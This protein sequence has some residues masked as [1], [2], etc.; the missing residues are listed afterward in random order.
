[1]KPKSITLKNYKRYGDE[2]TTLDLSGETVRLLVGK[3]GSGKTSFVDAIVWSLF[4]K[5]TANSDDVVNRQ[6]GKNCKVEFIFIIDQDEYS[7]IR[8]RK[9]DDYGNKVLVFKNK[10]NISP[11]RIDEANTLISSII[12]T[13][14]V[15]LISAV[16][17]SSEIYSSFLRGKGADRLKI[18]EN[19]LSLKIVNKWNEEIKK[20]RK[21]VIDNITELTEK[22]NKILVGV[23]TIDENI[24]NY[25]QRVKNTL[26]DLKKEKDDLLNFISENEGKLEEYRHIDIEKNLELNSLSD[27]IIKQ[28]KILEDKINIEKEKLKDINS[29]T[30]ELDLLK[31]KLENINNINVEDLIKEIKE[32]EIIKKKF[33]NLN[34]EKNKLEWQLID[35]EKELINIDNLSKQIILLFTKKKDVEQDL[36]CPTCHQDIKDEEAKNFTF[37]SIDNEIKKKQKESEEIDKRIFEAEANNKVIINDLNIILVKIKELNFKEKTFQYTTEEL[38]NFNKNKNEYY[39][40]ISYL[41]NNIVN[42]EKWNKEINERINGLKKELKEVPE[43]ETSAYESEFLLNLK[44][45]IN[46]LDAQ[47]ENAKQQISVIDEK[48]KSTYDKNYI[49]ELNTKVKNLKEHLKTTIEKIQKKEFEDKHYV[50]SLNF[51]SNDEKGFKRYVIKDMIDV[52]NE[53]L[54][55][56]VPMFFVDDTETVEITFD[57]NLV[58]TIKVDE[59]E[60]N[61]DSFSSGEKTRF[62]IA[63]SF[64]LFMVAKLYFSSSISLIVFDEILD[65]N[66]DEDSLKKVL[67]V[68]LDLGKTN[69]VLIISHRVELRNVFNNEITVSKDKYGYSKLKEAS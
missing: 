6:T 49:E 64:S 20:E 39:N 21:K 24:L 34:N 3:T 31:R 69:S 65:G 4:G 59:V 14:Y 45:T 30:K 58:E 33:D 41:E 50:F 26:I 61:L 36:K 7:V 42:D 10:N 35:T 32:Y 48:A 44:E 25:K 17:F 38:Q 22:K 19:I 23:E 13:T 54:A 52:F 67:N 47:T 1:M 66:L 8:Y 16:I 2:E 15:G 9:H 62:E 63:I 57:K 68:V 40:K 51:F 53:N 43:N 5:S 12:G 11:Q 60:V 18:F 37:E 28:N 27:S 46:K 55:N 29:N 56:Y